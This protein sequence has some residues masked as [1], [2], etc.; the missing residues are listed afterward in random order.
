MSGQEPR[1]E[2]R[3]AK[4]SP[5]TLRVWCLNAGAAAV[6]LGVALFDYRLGLIAGG[7]MLAGSALFGIVKGS[8]DARNPLRT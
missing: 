5:A 8:K 2:A 4:V 7:G 3:P 6:A 1:A